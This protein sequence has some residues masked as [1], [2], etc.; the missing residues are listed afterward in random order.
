MKEV[1]AREDSSVFVDRIDVPGE[2]LSA[3]LAEHLDEIKRTEGSWFRGIESLDKRIDL[4]LRTIAMARQYR[5]ES[6]FTTASLSA[7]DIENH[8]LSMH[9]NLCMAREQLSYQ[10]VD[11]PQYSINVI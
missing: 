5:S 7:I 3:R 8:L 4:V 2:S 11:L 6:E 9:D 1:F 10:E